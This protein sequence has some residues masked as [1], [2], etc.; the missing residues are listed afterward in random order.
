MGKQAPTQDRGAVRLTRQ[1]GLFGAISIIVGSMIGSGIFRSPAAIAEEVPRK[2]AF[3]GVWVGAGIVVLCGALTYAEL[4]SRFTRTGGV[5]I[6]IK[7][8]FGPLPAFLFG[9]TEMTVVRASGLAAT[10]TVVAEY[11][12]KLGG[13]GNDRAVHYVAA[14][15][16]ILVGAL[17]FIGIRFGAMLQNMTASLKYLS[18]LLLFVAAFALSSHPRTPATTVP[19]T[20]QPI[21]L[22]AI[23]LAMVSALWVYDGWADLTFVSGEIRRAERTVPLALVVGMIAVMVVYL[24]TN[25]AYISLLTMNQIGRAPLVAADAAQ[26]ILGS[27]GVVAISIATVVAAF[28]ALNGSMMTGSRIFFAMGEEGLFFAVLASVHSRFKTP[29]VAIVLATSL[30]VAFAL[31]QSFES[32]AAMFILAIWPFYALAAAALYVVRQKDRTGGSY[33]TPGY[34]ITPAVFILFALMITITG[35][36]SD[37]SYICSRFANQAPTHQPT[38][39]LLVLLLI[40]SGIP[41]YLIW[42]RYLRWRAGATIRKPGI[43]T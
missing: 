21:G 19:L 36:Y 6:Y 2:L 29:S 12:L 43:V 3:M 8:A 18:L 25:L 28:G 41:A 40:S 14:F 35:I 38:G 4:A 9:W 22:T 42:R 26:S 32:S 24:L 16:I 7:E 33:R 5:F 30:G 31:A 11:A 17:N 34:P 27:K 20:H 37:I 10:A 23:V 15:A 13:L 39:M 1:L